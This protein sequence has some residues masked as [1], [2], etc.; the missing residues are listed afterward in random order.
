MFDKVIRTELMKMLTWYF[1]IQTD[2]K[3][4]PGKS[5]KN[6]SKYIDNNIWNR[7]LGTYSDSNLTNNWN[8]LFTAT[9]LFRE[10][11]KEVAGK[12]NFQYLHDED[13]KVSEY[14]NRIHANKL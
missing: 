4:A 3:I 5:G 7:Y 1:A 13:R 6:I 11:A 12:Y 14:L 8:A 2:S 9:V 10:L